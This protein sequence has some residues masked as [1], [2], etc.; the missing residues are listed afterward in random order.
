VVQDKDIRWLKQ[1]GLFSSTLLFCSTGIVK[2]GLAE[3]HEYPSQI[4]TDASVTWELKSCEKKQNLVVS[5][6]LYF[7]SSNDG[8]YYVSWSNGIKL[9]DGEGNEYYPSKLQIQKKVVG[10]N[11]PLYLNL[12]KDARYKTTIDFRDV[13]ASTPYATLLEIGTSYGGAKFRGV[14]FVN[15]DG[16]I[17]EVPRSNRPPVNSGQSTPA[18]N[19]STAPIIPRIC[20]PLVGCT[21]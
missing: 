18:T 13:P 3:P 20:L 8:G 6:I 21:R 9:V 19:N 14:P 7:T 12:A 11:T 17:N 16:S 10:P 15:L 5:C 1:L 2:T 4:A